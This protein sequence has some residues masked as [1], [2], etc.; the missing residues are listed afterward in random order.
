MPWKETCAMDQRMQFIAVWQRDELTMSDLCRMFGVSRTT[1]YELVARFR[2]EG[3]T[4]LEDRSRAPRH[5]PNAVPEAV[6]RLLIRLRKKYGWGPVKLLDWMKLNR[7]G[8]MRPAAS[9]V[10][11]LLRREGLIKPRQR[12]R[13]APAYGAPYAIAVE[14]NDLWCIDFKGWFRTADGLRCYP[15]TMSD[16]CSRYLLCCRA[17][18]GETHALTAPWIERTMRKFGLP[19]AIR[20]DGGEPFASRGLGALSALSVKWIKLGIVPERIRP[21]HPEQNGRHERLHGTLKGRCRIGANLRDQQRNFDRFVREYNLERPHQSLKGKTPTMLYRNSLRSYP[22]R[23]PKIEYESGL[24]VRYV[25]ASGQIS[26]RGREWYVSAVLADEPIALCPIE[27]GVW[28][29]HFGPLAI[30]LLDV[31]NKRIEPIETFIDVPTLH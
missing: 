16:A 10:D 21:G 1:G 25:R 13:R 20:T 9:T 22:V 30:G 15:L 11:E 3:Y 18:G 19:S 31:R 5:H 23:M 27:D 28:R 26:W 24:D 7:P 8:L 17:L 29:I 14:P 6:R 4:G 2:A 12:V